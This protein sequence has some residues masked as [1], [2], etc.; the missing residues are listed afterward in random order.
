MATSVVDARADTTTRVEWTTCPHSN[1]GFVFRHQFT[2]HT[3]LVL[4]PMAPVP[5]LTK[6][7]RIAASASA[8]LEAPHR[9]LDTSP[10]FETRLSIR[11]RSTRTTRSTS[12]PQ[13]HRSGLST[14]FTTASSA[15]PRSVAEAA[16]LVIDSIDTFARWIVPSFAL[17]NLL[18]NTTQRI[19]FLATSSN[20]KV[21]PR[22]KRPEPI[23]LRSGL[24]TKIKFCQ[25]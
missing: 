15:P 25:E 14:H 2:R 23:S 1:G 6:N 18:K 17:N 21:V 3:P 7:P 22:T 10:P 4:L 12:S 20:S 9:S 19:R 24:G 11:F 5:Q 16:S 13:S 8:R